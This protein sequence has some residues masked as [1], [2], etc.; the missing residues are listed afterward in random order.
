MLKTYLREFS[1]M[2]K[3][4]MKSDAENVLEKFDNNGED[5]FEIF[6]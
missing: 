4:F 6:Q 2:V 3:T 1:M 5:I